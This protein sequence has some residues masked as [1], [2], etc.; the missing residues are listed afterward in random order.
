MLILIGVV[1]VQLTLTSNET[2]AR[3]LPF[4]GP[5]RLIERSIGGSGSVGPAVL[6]DLAYAA[7]LFILAVYI[8]HRRAPR[9]L[10]LREPAGL[11]A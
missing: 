5:Q 9:R 1:G 8:V 10:E 2:I 11:P 3:L 7:A 4:W 6:V